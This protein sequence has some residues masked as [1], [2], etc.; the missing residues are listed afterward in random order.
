MGTNVDNESLE[1]MEDH[2]GNSNQSNVSFKDQ[3]PPFGLKGDHDI[4][5][6]QTRTRKAGDPKIN[7]VIDDQFG[8]NTR[9]TNREKEANMA[10][11]PTKF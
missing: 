4:I 10:S 8:N 3:D 1:I 6:S 11:S 2:D 7:I 9:Y 5:H